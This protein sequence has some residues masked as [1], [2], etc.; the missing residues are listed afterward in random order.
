MT[1]LGE[2]GYIRVAG[3]RLV[4]LLDVAPIGPDYQPA[5]G[6]ADTLSFECSLD[7]HRLVVNSGTSCYGTSAERQRQRGTSAHNTV[8]IDGEDS[9]EV[10]GGFRVARRARPFGLAVRE[11]R[12]VI[13]AC[14]HDG[15]RRLRGRPVHRRQWTIDDRSL[16]VEDDVS[17]PQ[18]SAQARFHIHP[19]VQI[20]PGGEAHEGRL[21][22]PSGQRV[23]WIAETGR[24]AIEPSTWHPRFGAAIPNHCLVVAL[25]GGRSRLRLQWA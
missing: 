17:N 7:G 16:L 13:V 1:H 23:R 3:P 20:E 12:E 11:G 24:P 2:S 14:S 15:Y 9:S 10:W 19:D 21:R 5:H 8:V 25:D 18:A 22:L 6:H 4:A